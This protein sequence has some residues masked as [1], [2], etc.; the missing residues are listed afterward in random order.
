MI[1]CNLGGGDDVKGKRLKSV[2]CLVYSYNESDSL[3]DVQEILMEF[4]G[5]P[6]LMKVS[7][8]GDGASIVLTT[9]PLREVNMEK[10]GK[11]VIKRISSNNLFANA[12]DRKVVSFYCIYSGVE[13]VTAGV[14]FE[15]D[16]TM[17]FS[18]VNLGDQLFVFNEIPTY[19]C[20]SEQL[21]FVPI[22]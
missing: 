18:I 12:I 6:Y 4:E 1:N 17:K 21:A 8:G 2:H 22:K 19:I 13:K 7:G 10:Y 20:K 5:L 15:F 3:D 16:N 14:G 11:L 9:S